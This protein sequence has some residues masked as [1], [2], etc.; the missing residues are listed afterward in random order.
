MSDRK[1]N[2]GVSVP[3]RAKAELISY[4]SRVFIAGFQ[5]AGSGLLPYPGRCPGLVSLGPLARKSRRRRALNEAAGFL[6]GDGVVGRG[7]F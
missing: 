3:H 6:E 7:G 5:P 2:T 1:T 4:A